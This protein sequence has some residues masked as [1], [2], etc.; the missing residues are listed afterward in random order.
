MANWDKI[1]SKWNVEDRRWTRMAWAVG[2]IWIW[3]IAIALAI[4]YFNWADSALNFLW[5]N[6]QNNRVVQERQTNTTEFDWEDSYE[7]FVWKILGSEDK[8]WGDSFKS[9]WIKYEKPKL[10]LFRWVT[11][12]ACWWAQ[13]QSWP[14]YCSLDKTIYLDETFFE[15]MKRDFWAKWW[16]V[17]QAYVV[18]HEYWHHIQNLLWITKTVK[19]NSDSVKLETQ[20]DCLAW[21]W[22]SK[23][24]NIFESPDEIYEA[25]DAAGSVWDDRIQKRMTWHVSPENWT[26]WSS[27]QRKYWFSVGYKYW[28]FEKCNTFE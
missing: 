10:V 18:A 26:H 28:D 24:S 9:S 11:Q 15:E 7:K 21:I 27:K 25:I 2:W 23:I 14:H 19:S 5:E 20:A 3:T 1:K 22:A 4:G 12:S 16:D 6:L 13:S 8:L 17:A